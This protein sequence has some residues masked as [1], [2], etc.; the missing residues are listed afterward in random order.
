MFRRSCGE[1]FKKCIRCDSRPLSGHQRCP[2]FIN[3][4]YTLIAGWTLNEIIFRIN[5]FFCILNEM[6]INGERKKMPEQPESK[7][8]TKRN[9]QTFTIA[10]GVTADATVAHSQSIF[11]DTNWNSE[12]TLQRVK[13]TKNKEFFASISRQRNII[14]FKLH[15][16]GCRSAHN[17]PSISI[18]SFN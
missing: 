6:E 11:T 1:S 10:C 4:F 9:K 7:S 3:F 5:W 2:S 16:A 13:T 15:L 8:R 12:A 17:E 18:I 14:Q